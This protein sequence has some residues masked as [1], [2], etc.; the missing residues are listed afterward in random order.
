MIENTNPIPEKLK[1]RFEKKTYKTFDRSGEKH[2]NWEIIKPVG[3]DRTRKVI[4]LCRCI[5][6][7]EQIRNTNF[8][9]RGFPKG[10]GCLKESRGRHKG[11]N[12]RL[13]SI[14]KGMIERCYY[15]KS[16]GYKYYG[17]R[18]ITV[19][20][21]WR[22]CFSNFRDDMGEPTSIKHSL[23]R[24]NNDGNYEPSNCRWATAKEQAN[25]KRQRKPKND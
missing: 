7:N 8:I 25:N 23:D 20:D 4:Y 5:C 10:C 9:F 2:Y 13:Y 6:G 19:C 12:T 15:E 21:R 1:E 3:V 18:G 24:I 17:L 22:N 14:Y 11:S 16:K